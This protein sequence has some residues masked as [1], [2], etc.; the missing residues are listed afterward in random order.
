V[1]N[2]K[3]RLRLPPLFSIIRGNDHHKPSF[4]IAFAIAAPAN[5]AANSVHIYQNGVKLI[6]HV[7]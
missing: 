1:K 4:A 6:I 3:F 5:T 2:G 7:P